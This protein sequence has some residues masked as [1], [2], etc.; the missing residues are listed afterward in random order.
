MN[1]YGIIVT[2][3][4]AILRPAT[5]LEAVSILKGLRDSGDRIAS[6]NRTN[7]TEE[8]VVDWDWRNGVQ[9]ASEAETEAEL[10]IL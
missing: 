7:P 5:E 3:K 8:S 4:G 1:Y 10:S 6:L 2:R 9:G